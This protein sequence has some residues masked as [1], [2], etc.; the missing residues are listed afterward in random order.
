M[1]L[2]E[3]AGRKNILQMHP[4]PDKKTPSKL[5]RKLA[6]PAD[7]PGK[8]SFSVASGPDTDWELVVTIAGKEAKRETIG[9]QPRWHAID[10]SL[11]PWKGQTVEIS[12]ENHANGWAWEFSYWDVI[13]MSQ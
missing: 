7:K 11:E 5:V 3:Y 9:P 1:K 4:Y 12:L 2:T 6:V 13:Q 8:L 10:I